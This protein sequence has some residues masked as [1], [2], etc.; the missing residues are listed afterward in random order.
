[1]SRYF[2]AGAH[3]PR[4]G[5]ENRP[6]AAGK[7]AAKTGKEN[8]KKEAELKQKTAQRGPAVRERKSREGEVS[9][10]TVGRG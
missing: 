6:S 7:T 10:M 5:F 2:S 3:F 1:M 9:E 8:E 4:I